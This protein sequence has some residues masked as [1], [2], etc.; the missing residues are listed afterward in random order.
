MNKKVVYS[1]LAAAA[2]PGIAHADAVI[3]DAVNVQQWAGGKLNSDSTLYTSTGTVISYSLGNRVAGTYKL[4]IKGIDATNGKVTVSVAGKKVSTSGKSDSEEVSVQFSLASESEVTITASIEGNNKA[5]KVGEGT[6]TLVYDFQDKIGTIQSVLTSATNTIDGWKTKGFDRAD[7]FNTRTALIQS[8][9]DAI[10][11]DVDGSLG[12][13][14]KYVKYKIYDPV[15]DSNELITES[16]QVLA[17]ATTAFE[18][19]ITKLLTDVTNGEDYKNATNGYDALTDAQ[20]AQAKKNY[21]AL[22]KDVKGYQNSVKN[23]DAISSYVSQISTIKSDITNLQKQVDVLGGGNVK[24]HAAVKTAISTARSSRSTYLTDL[25]SLKEATLEGDSI[26]N[27]GN[28]YANLQ[29]A[30]RKVLSDLFAQLTQVEAADSAF[31]RDGIADQKKDSL[32]QRI[33]DIGAGLDEAYKLYYGTLKKKLDDSNDIYLEQLGKQVKAEKDYKDVI[34]NYP[35][36]QKGVADAVKAVKTA[37]DNVNTADGKSSDKLENLDLTTQAAAVDKALETLKD[38][39]ADEQA[40]FDA[41]GAVQDSIDVVNGLYEDF[42]ATIDT[43]KYGDELA[44]N[45]AWKSWASNIQKDYV[46]KRL[47][48]PFT[49]AK[50]K[51]L[52]ASD[53]FYTKTFPANL[54]NVKDKIASV[55]AKAIKAADNYNKVVPAIAAAK[56]SLAAAKAKVEKLEIYS[57]STLNVDKYNYKGKIEA[58]EAIIATAE[59]NRDLAFTDANKKSV[60]NEKNADAVGK[61][62]FDSTEIVAVINHINENYQTDQAN[63]Q[64]NADAKAL[65]AQKAAV[66]SLS[67]TL[68]TKK[69]NIENY[70]DNEYADETSKARDKAY[71]DIKSR[72]EKV[73]Y[74]TSE[75]VDNAIGD[76]VKDATQVSALYTRIL[77]AS[78]TSDSILARIDTARAAYKDN[79]TAKATADA[80]VKTLND[81]NYATTIKSKAGDAYTN[82][83]RSPK[84]EA[85]ELDELIKNIGDSIASVTDSISKLYN[86]ETLKANYEGEKG[87][88]KAIIDPIAQAIKD[89]ES[90]AESLQKNYTSYIKQTGKQRE[91][92]NAITEAKVAAENA[93]PAAGKTYFSEKLL[94]QYANDA[95]EILTT[96]KKNYDDENSYNT[97]SNIINTSLKDLDDKIAQVEQDTKDNLKNYN[98]LVKEKESVQNTWNEQ[99]TTLAG[100]VETSKLP[101]YQKQLDEYLDQLN[102]YGAEIDT[103]YNN[104]DAKLPGNLTD[105]TTK[106]TRL[107]AD[108]VSLVQKA[109]DPE[110]VNEQIEIDNNGMLEAINNAKGAADDAY[111]AA[112]TEVNK[113]KNLKSTALKDALGTVQTEFDNVNTTL[114]EKPTEISQTFTEANSKF[115]EVNAT[116]GVVFD[117]DSTYVTTLNGYRD[118]INSALDGFLTKAKG[119]ISSATNAAIAD[120]ETRIKTDSTT[121][122][123]FDKVKDNKKFDGINALKERIADIKDLVGEDV[124]TPDVVSIDTKINSLAAE[125][126][127]LETKAINDAAG[128][129]LDGYIGTAEKDVD[130]GK[131]YLASDPET[132]SAYNTTV[133]STVGAAREKYNTSKSYSTDYDA[134][135]ALVDQYNSSNEYKTTKENTEKRDNLLALIGTQDSLLNNVYLPSIEDYAVY[136]QIKV[137]TG[138]FHDLQK[139][140][141]GYKD[142]A[143]EAQKS[144]TGW[145]TETS[146]KKVGT[147]G[148]NLVDT[149]KNGTLYN[150]EKTYLTSLENQVIAAYN[151][152]AAENTDLAE[153]EKSSIDALFKA[154][155]NAKDAKELL[156]QQKNLSAE[157]NK[158]YTAGKLPQELA[159]IKQALSDSLNAVNTAFEYEDSTVEANYKDAV[160]KLVAD[161]EAIAGKIDKSS[162]ILVDKDAIT[163]ATDELKKQAEAIAKE[164]DKSNAE[165]KAEKLAQEKEA[166]KLATAIQNIKNEVQA[167]KDKLD[168]YE[169]PRAHSN[170]FLNKYKLCDSDIAT[171]ESASDTASVAAKVRDRIAQIENVAAY[172]EGTFQLDSL[173]D[174]YNTLNSK[175]EGFAKDA[176]LPSDLKE[177]TDLR[178]AIKK[179]IYG[180]ATSTPKVDGIEKEIDNDYATAE[181]GTNYQARKSEIDAQLANIEKANN[182]IKENIIQPQGDV[183][184]NGIVDVYDLQAVINNVDSND[185]ASDI[186]NDGIVDIFDVQAEVNLLEQ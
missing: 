15:D 107:E 76:D 50:N 103:L 147:D 88:K 54:K 102:A 84:A 174:K 95:A 142:D 150:E 104:G 19:Q 20:K 71:N 109:T 82:G 59:K 101:E 89:A 56:D 139:S 72:Y 119:A 42:K 131:A 69:G 157:L 121:I 181:S 73:D 172:R 164:I 64:K 146:I 21:D 114:A 80:D 110:S 122:A 123:G 168:Q 129:D 87:V 52:P 39:C 178:N 169:N 32:T 57:D 2:L 12:G 65:A 43:L 167:S 61:L 182:L 128:I 138:G 98:T 23:H 111:S 30:G 153:S 99:S 144:G 11:D 176:F 35:D 51:K 125:F 18:A 113:Y 13:Y 177:I 46:T 22:E 40:L 79:E 145:P 166:Q 133:K 8:T 7:E 77:A 173:K 62:D 66:R 6:V 25:A 17:E 90:K 3:K 5:F 136:E 163:T 93:D 165:A 83:T 75:E 124:E 140:L 94:E 134:I 154:I 53:D 156:K 179:A 96:I 112:V 116:K 91:T 24:A 106:L 184:G 132:L 158:L 28:G 38:K 33:S 31:F 34:A 175:I 16:N 45:N 108:I 29:A 155:N 152:W 74:P 130:A 49:D 37:I 151:V 120:Y 63:W 170:Q 58:A 159:D 161:K 137:I 55:K 70:L 1:L 85:K 115:K 78:A 4:T 162:N 86:A 183:D 105:Y 127:S 41:Q 186:N 97:E 92:V 117:K 160:D 180:D 143:N 26:N 60:T 100:A 48:N 171:I 68:A 47:V 81:T 148:K 126:D 149:K 67:G 44:V 27:A 135:V 185:P 10:K 9:V 141:D 118:D 36:E 14:D